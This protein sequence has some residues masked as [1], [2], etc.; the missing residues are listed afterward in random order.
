MY[1][2]KVALDSP[3]TLAPMAGATDTAFRL[4]AKKNT[5]CAL[6]CTEMI[7]AKGLVYA[8]ERTRQLLRFS[9][10]ERPLSAQIFGSEPA[11]MA[12]AASILAREGVDIIDIN[13]GCPVPK[14]V[15]NGEGVA[16]MRNPQKAYAIIKAVASA[17]KCPVTVKMRKGWDSTEVNALTISLLA[18]DAG[19][20]AVAI[21]GRTCDQLY[22]GQADW[23]II[24]KIV[25]ALSIPVIG[26]GDIFT[27]Q[28]ACS[29]LQQTGCSAVMIGRGAL[30]NPWIFPQ[31]WHYLQYGE[32]L[33]EP[34]TRE[35]IDTALHHLQLLIK[36][37]G[38]DQ[39]VKKMRKHALWYLKGLRGVKA[40]KQQIIKAETYDN[41][42]VI[43]SSL[44]VRKNDQTRR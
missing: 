13:M 8:W 23:E 30:G 4:L 31:T 22:S 24:K 11:V 2:G 6:V 14:V 40:V 3:L 20:A 7:S 10:K 29:M 25:A 15:K 33:P 28:D 38:E 18:Q 17:V 41:F 27:P 44:L 32:Q 43:L 9:E 37:L 42:K 35:R 1:I 36:L 34:T 19:A 12:E 26:N 16:L 5:G 21:H 39:A